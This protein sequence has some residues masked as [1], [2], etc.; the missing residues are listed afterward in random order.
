[1]YAK[2]PHLDWGVD[3]GDYHGLRWT[4]PA[5]EPGEHC[6]L[7]VT[8]AWSPDDNAD[9]ANTFFAVGGSAAWVLGRL[10]RT[11]GQS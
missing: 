8:A 1:M 3:Y 10:A 4:L 11:E 2:W 9:D 5:L 6:V 7:A